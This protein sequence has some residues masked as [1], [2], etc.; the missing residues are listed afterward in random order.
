MNM[1]RVGIV[2]LL[3]L[4]LNLAHAA[5]VQKMLSW[6]TSPTPN[7]TYNVYNAVGS[8]GT[9][10]YLG[11][12][13][14]ALGYMVTYDDSQLAKWYVTAKD[15]NGLESIPSNIVQKDPV[16]PLP[17]GLTFEA[18]AGVI[19]PPFYVN[20][21]VIQQD[22]STTDGTGGSATYSFNI[23]NPGG[24]TVNMLVNAPS[25]SQDSLYVNVDVQPD[26]VNQIW[27][28]PNT[29]GYEMRSLQWRSE[30]NV[31][32]F[33][34]TAAQ[35]TL[36]VRGREAGTQ[37]DRISITPLSVAPPPTNSFVLTAP[38]MEKTTLVNGD[39]TLVSASIRN[40]GSTDLFVADGALAIVA[41]G[42]SPTNSGPYLIIS[43]VPAMT[44]KSNA[45]VTFTGTLLVTNLYVGLWN[46]YLF[47]R[48][49]DVLNFSPLTPFN[50]A[51]EVPPLALPPAPQN[52]QGIVVSARRLKLTWYYPNPN[53]VV[54]TKIERKRG[55][56]PYTLIKTIAGSTQTS[57]TDTS[58]W[59]KTEYW[60]RVRSINS[61]G[62]GPWSTTLYYKTP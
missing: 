54:T 37:F 29:A 3:L 32:T 44:I 35:H 53:S 20:G 30:T 22:V 27:D 47:A 59:K 17:S 7:V 60:Y 24:Y 36:I 16:V 1:K 56:E 26:L 33:N 45:S 13:G 21:G 57:W 38:I 34:L 12:A 2:L 18:E 15:A 49:G 8:A 55:A 28:I 11:N 50:I 43:V 42:V 5:M 9:F 61:V 52:L 25:G 31:H 19:S 39:S 58:L 4:S 40:T 41:P 14:N 51:M 46:S 23:A 48:I 10:Y 62:A 6:D